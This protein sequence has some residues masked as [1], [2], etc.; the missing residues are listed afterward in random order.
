MKALPKVAWVL[1]YGGLV[2]F[3][4]LTV[5][6]L[7]G[8]TFLM[9]GWFGFHLPMWLAA[10]AAVILS[11]LGA[12]HWGVVLGMQDKLTAPESN[13]LL[14]YSVVPAV[15]AWFALLL[16]GKTALLVMAVLVVAAYVADRILLLPKLNSNYAQLR[17]HLTVI[18]ILLL[19]AA[20]V[21]GES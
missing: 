12:V 10:Y 3:F 7:S 9:Q 14:I 5:G 15:L 20:S 2:P 6:L 21:A 19:I 13:T 16:P 8:G 11:F 1:G 18:V 17:L 4:A